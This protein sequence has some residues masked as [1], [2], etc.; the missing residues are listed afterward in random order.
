M[1]RRDFIKYSLA[2][3]FAGASL[4]ATESAAFLPA[5]LLRFLFSRTA[6]A[7]FRSAPARAMTTAATSN[8][9]RT[10][11]SALRH[12]S[13]PRKMYS[14]APLISAGVEIGGISALSP[15]LFK[16]VVNHNATTIWIMDNDKPVEFFVTGTN[17]TEQ[18]LSGS[19]VIGYNEL[20]ITGKP[21]E[22]FDH[23]RITID[24]LETFSVGISPPKDLRGMR[25]I[26]LSGRVDGDNNKAIVFERSAP[27]VL[28]NTREVST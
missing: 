25:L 12:Y 17:T 7:A 19:L 18:K 15:E 11:L 1:R 24:P 16:I 14:T 5:L 9:R 4:I 26:D 23:G 27:I 20:G 6:V 21:T 2:S 28:A 22:Y 13:T 10:Q 8:L 3:G